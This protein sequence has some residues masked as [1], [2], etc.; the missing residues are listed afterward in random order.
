M[1]K[2]LG[3]TL[4]TR[5][6]KNLHPIAKITHTSGLNGSVCLRPLSRYFEDYIEEKPLKLG[7]SNIKHVDVNLELINGVGKKR[8]FKFQGFNSVANAKGLIGKTVFVE[9]SSDD[10]IN[11]ISKEL[12]GYKVITNKG[13]KVGYLEDVMWLPNNDAYVINKGDREY[14]IPIIPEIVLSIDHDINQINIKHMDGLID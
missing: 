5:A 14:L 10:K 8:K 11:L 12:L 3:L 1:E 7:Y 2:E 13:E 6:K 9:A 4:L